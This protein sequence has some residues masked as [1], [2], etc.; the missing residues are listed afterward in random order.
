MG[1]TWTPRRPSV[2]LKYSQT[3]VSVPLGVTN[4]CCR[5]L[6]LRGLFYSEGVG[7][8]NLARFDQYECAD[9]TLVGRAD[10]IMYK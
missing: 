2:Q 1:P 3:Q 6:A 9:N 10:F 8:R 5:H 7:L 4:L